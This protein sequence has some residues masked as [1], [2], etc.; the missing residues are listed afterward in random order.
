MMKAMRKQ[1]FAL[2][3][4][5]ILEAL[6]E[7]RGQVAYVSYGDRLLVGVVDTCTTRVKAVFAAYQVLH[8]ED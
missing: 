1:Q 8:G 6:A 3:E 7:E 2:L 5:R 4:A